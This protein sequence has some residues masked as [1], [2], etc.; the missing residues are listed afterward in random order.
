MTLDARIAQLSD[1]DARRLL[2]SLTRPLAEDPARTTTPDAA[3]VLALT[4]AFGAPAITAPPDEGDL[5]RTA[6]RLLAADP[7]TAPR[8]TAL[9]DGP[10]AERFIDPNTIA[11]TTAVLLALQLHVRIERTKDGQWKLLIEK[12][13]MSG[14]ALKPLVD[15]LVAFLSRGG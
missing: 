8:L 3:L 1:A 15:K 13:S 12:P 2:L 10:R 7:A 14:A 6:L 11:I 5:A 9:L 4:T